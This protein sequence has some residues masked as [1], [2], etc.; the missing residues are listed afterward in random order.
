[1]NRLEFIK[2]FV[3]IKESKTQDFEISY[4]DFNGTTGSVNNIGSFN[5]SVFSYKN[6]TTKPI[7]ELEIKKDFL[8]TAKELAKK[9]FNSFDL[10]K[11]K[12]YTLNDTSITSKHFTRIVQTK[13]MSASNFIAVNN[14]IGPGNCIIVSEKNY[15]LFELIKLN[16]WGR[17]YKFYFAP[18]NDIIVYRCNEIEQPGLK[19]IF[20]ENNYA[21]VPIGSNPEKNF[22]LI[23]LDTRKKKLERILNK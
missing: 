21:L 20:C 13:I 7:D 22:C 5:F 19:L 4:V 6:K 1:M 9:S 8:Q 14:L 17:S 18:I 10:D 16:S 15:Q 2:D 23:K 12:T 11:K 3:D